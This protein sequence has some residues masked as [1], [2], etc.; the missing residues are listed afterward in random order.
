MILTEKNQIK[1][2]IR[3]VL[4]AFSE[5]QASGEK[6]GKSQKLEN[7]VKTLRKEA[8]S[9]LKAKKASISQGKK[10][11]GWNFSELNTLISSVLLGKFN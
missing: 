8:G 1:E 11:K 7:I 3:V 4:I 5:Q 2:Q 9:S 10:G 6:R